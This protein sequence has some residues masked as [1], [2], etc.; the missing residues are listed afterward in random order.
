[1][2]RTVEVRSVREGV[3]LLWC[4]GD[5]DGARHYAFSGK[6][7]ISNINTKID[8]LISQKRK[9]IIEITTIKILLR[10]IAKSRHSKLY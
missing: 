4:M 6:G 5:Y 7:D 10:K 3:Y 9:K 8:L 1:M 2:S